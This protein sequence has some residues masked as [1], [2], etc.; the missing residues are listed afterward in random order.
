MAE[1]P[2]PVG[3][4]GAGDA[5]EFDDD[6][7]VDDDDLD[8]LEMTLD[9]DNLVR[10]FR[11]ME[12]VYENLVKGPTKTRKVINK[13]EKARIIGVRAQQI[14]SGSKPLVD[15]GR[16]RNPI[17][18]AMM[19]LEQKKLPMLIQRQIPGKDPHNPQTE[20]VSPNQLIVPH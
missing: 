9:T 10:K 1:V 6:V 20:V 16:E 18:I 2:G 7:D 8:E 4:V 13:Y 3:D 17:K 5:D 15:I 12:S 19:E 14:E 11:D